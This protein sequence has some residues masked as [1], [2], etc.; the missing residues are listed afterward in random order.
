VLHG[1]VRRTLVRG[2]TVFLDGRLVSSPI[3]QLVKPETA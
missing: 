1:L 2:Q 3:G